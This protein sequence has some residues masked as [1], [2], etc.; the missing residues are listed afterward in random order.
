MQQKEKKNNLITSCTKLEV[1]ELDRIEFTE[2]IIRTK[3]F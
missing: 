1:K 2:F 3:S